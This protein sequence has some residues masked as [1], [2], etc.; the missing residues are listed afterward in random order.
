MVT[1]EQL[2][3]A[4]G[5]RVVLFL[6]TEQTRIWYEGYL[7]RYTSYDSM[8]YPNTFE[9]CIGDN[10]LEIGPDDGVTELT[11]LPDKGNH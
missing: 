2:A 7:I 4:V 6:G 11:I 9:V 5:K 10:Y 8:G 3:N 1:G